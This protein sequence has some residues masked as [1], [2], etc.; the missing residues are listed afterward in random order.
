[1]T[2][3]NTEYNECIMQFILQN[4]ING[5]FIYELLNKNVNIK[6]TLNGILGSLIND[7]MMSKIAN[8]L[9]K[10]D[11]TSLT[12]MSSSVLAELICDFVTAEIK[13]QFTNKY[14]YIN[15]KWLVTISDSR[16]KFVNI[17]YEIAAISDDDGNQMYDFMKQYDVASDEDIKQQIV[18]NINGLNV[19]SCSVDLA[20]LAIK[21]RNNENVSNEAEQILHLFY[22]VVLENKTGNEVN[23]E[24][25][26]KLYDAFSNTFSKILPNWWCSKCCYNNKSIKINGQYLSFDNIRM[27]SCLVCGY[28]KFSAITDQLRNKTQQNYLRDSHEEVL[29]CD[30]DNVT[31]CGYC[32]KLMKVLENYHKHKAFNS[33]ESLQ[34]LNQKDVLENIS[35]KALQL[36]NNKEEQQ[37]LIDECK[38]YQEKNAVN[39]TKIKEDKSDNFIATKTDEKILFEI[40]GIQLCK[41]TENDFK[42]IALN[43]NKDISITTIHLLYDLMYKECN[44]YVS[45][46]RSTKLGDSCLGVMTN[47]KHVLQKHFNNNKCAHNIYKCIDGNCDKC[48]NK[49]NKCNDH[50]CVSKKRQMQTRERRG[51]IRYSEPTIVKKDNYNYYVKNE[52]QNDQLFQEELD[53][54]HLNILHKTMHKISNAEKEELKTTELYDDDDDDNCEED[55]GDILTVETKKK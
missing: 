51:N 25:M 40:D 38:V 52:I 5:I 48:K 21:L 15:G 26:N 14:N 43:T 7:E 24:L 3:K 37:K 53:N 8:K 33:A 55:V 1:M 32:Q 19:N 45:Q 47:W 4:N 39:D 30:E 10:S 42:V 18:D 12:Q 23:F 50:N 11:Y 49:L 54:I 16:N 35:L 9:S 31:N 17:L 22:N 28:D 36:I 41:M 27:R 46:K 20:K 2:K 13:N 6:K 44:N 34:Q 29:H